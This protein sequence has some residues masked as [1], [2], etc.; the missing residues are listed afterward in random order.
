MKKTILMVAVALSM[1][2]SFGSIAMPIEATDHGPQF[3]ADKTY[4]VATT[5]AAAVKESLPA[6]VNDRVAAINTAIT[7]R[8][9]SQSFSLAQP[10]MTLSMRISGPSSS[11]EHW[12][13]RETEQV[14]RST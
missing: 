8:E 6:V 10:T 11:I 5:P 1:A 7:Q 4:S 13:N 3:K 9:V 2:A 14:Q 12:R